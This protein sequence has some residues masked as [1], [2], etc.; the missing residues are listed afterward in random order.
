MKKFLS[1]F[2]LA[3]FVVCSA[4]ASKV[5]SFVA[6][7]DS[8]NVNLGTRTAI[9]VTKDGVTMQFSQGMVTKTGHYRVYDSNFVSF[10]CESNIDSIVFTG[11]T[12]GTVKYGIGCFSASTGT[13]TTS[14]TI[15][16]WVG[17]A[18]FV[19][20]T[21]TTYQVRFTQV[22]VYINQEESGAED[23][24]APVI[25]PDGGTF[26]GSQEVTITCETEGASIYYTTDGTDPTAS[27]TAYT[28]AFTLTESATVKAIAI[29][30]SAQSSITSASFTAL[31]SVSTIKEAQALETGTTFSFNGEVTVTY[32]HAKSKSVWI[33]DASGYGL[34]YN[35]SSPTY[36][37]G[38]VIPAGWTANNTVYY[39]V[40]EFASPSG[41][42]EA[43]K[44][45]T[46]DYNTY[47]PAE[48]S[49]DNVNEYLM[50]ENC[51]MNSNFSA[52]NFNV[53]EDSAASIPV[54]DKF[55]ITKPTYSADSTYNV[56]ALVTIYRGA[57]ELYPVEITTYKAPA[58][59][60]YALYVIKALE[61]E[62]WNLASGELMADTA[63]STDEQLVLQLQNMSLADVNN[64][65]GYF[66]FT[67]KLA[68]NDSAWTEIDSYRLGP[69]SENVN[70]DADNFINTDFDPSNIGDAKYV[71]MQA[72]K[73][74]FIEAPAAIYDLYV[75][76]TPA[77]SNIMPMSVDPTSASARL[78]IVNPNSTGVTEM[79]G[80]LRI[81]SVKYYN[82]NGIET[83]EPTQGVNIRVIT[84]DN[85]TT[86]AVKVLK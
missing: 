62:K 3:L 77:T 75:E 30:G 78:F 31:P 27:S 43:T 80:D 45:A 70:F 11:T 37:Q 40:P 41:L 74:T 69:V 60:P 49:N 56:L 4:S 2:V 14:G 86:K 10:T 82:L 8:G 85:G 81:A 5:V 55:K 76:F 83:A 84:Y 39:N 47:S 64:G 66:A 22:D 15:G 33:K 13:Y 32:F 9:T 61:G 16:H 38:Q 52:I 59:E 17:P 6:P 29:K 73:A 65:D 63:L 68:S 19:R 28:A 12:E 54:Y 46:V 57:V 35:V 51:T 7:T 18:T 25:S 23:V 48:L 71:S 36:E 50:V 67:T 34:I 24:K 44:T 72:G 1:F 53:T 58:E 20:F 21:T 79:P 26:A 42:S